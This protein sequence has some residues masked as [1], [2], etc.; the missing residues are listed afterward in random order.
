MSV[1]ISQQISV[2]QINDPAFK[3]I[4][5]LGG[6][7]TGKTSLIE[8]LIK[9]LLGHNRVGVVDCDVGQSHIGPPGTIAWGLIHNTFDGWESI[10]V[11][12]FYFIGALSPAENTTSSLVGLKIIY[13]KAKDQADKIIIDTTGFI[14]KAGVTLKEHQ[15]ELIQPDIIIALQKERELE[16]ILESFKA[17]D[18]PLIFRIKVEGNMNSKTGENRV[19][20]RQQKFSEYFNVLNRLELN[21]KS[22]GIRSSNGSNHLGIN[23]GHEAVDT[24]PLKQKQE[25]TNRLVS[26]R[27]EKGQ[28]IALGLIDTIDHNNQKM[29]VFSP[30]DD[31]KL[32]KT[33]VV[34]TIKVLLSK[35]TV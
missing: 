8:A 32:V 17:M 30:L 20:F 31:E 16:P 4:M 10:P 7:D 9:M 25:L 26:L 28:D 15:I 21:L 29:I 13:D 19:S 18:K 1:F 3:T 6:S 11:R 14:E 2:E 22:T 33:V 34:G 12:D 5:V 35:E 23:P 27:N 24:Q